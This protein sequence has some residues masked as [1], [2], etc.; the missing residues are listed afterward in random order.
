MKLRVHHGT[1]FQLRSPRLYTPPYSD[2]GSSRGP[3]QGWGLEIAR[4]PRAV[5]QC[6]PASKS[7]VVRGKNSRPQ[8]SVHSDSATICWGEEIKLASWLLAARHCAVNM[9]RIPAR[10]LQRLQHCS[11]SCAVPIPGLEARD[12]KHTDLT[13]I[14]QNPVR[15]DENCKWNNSSF[16]RYFVFLLLHIQFLVI[17]RC[18]NAFQII[19]VT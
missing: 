8:D 2:H 4:S 19:S 11:W 14:F 17:I 16:S 13:E 5:Q 10:W 9:P 3:V 15:K 18:I 12:L 1:G 6:T 7:G